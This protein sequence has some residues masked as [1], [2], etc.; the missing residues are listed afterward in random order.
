MSQNYKNHRRFSPSYHFISIPVSAIVLVG[1]IVNLV[2]ASS[3]TVYS[4]SLILVLTLLLISAFFHARIFALKTQN[5]VIRVEENLRHYIL[6]GKP[7]DARLRMGQI[8]ALRFASDAEFPKLAQRAID[9]S[10]SN[11]DIKRAIQNWKADY[12]RV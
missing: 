11:D 10:L 9:E 12:N 7:L 2:H 6:T 3:E 4:A 8:I 5:R 1:A